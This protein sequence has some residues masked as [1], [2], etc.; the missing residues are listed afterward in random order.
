MACLLGIV[1]AFSTILFWTIAISSKVLLLTLWI[2]LGV[3]VCGCKD[4][5]PLHQSV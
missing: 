4:K 1:S 2:L 5:D 3:V